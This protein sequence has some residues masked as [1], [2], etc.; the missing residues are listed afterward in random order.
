MNCNTTHYRANSS[1]VPGDPTPLTRGLPL[2][3]PRTSALR[4]RIIREKPFLKRLYEEWYAG[5]AEA[6]PPGHGAILELG[7]GAGFLAEHV[8]GL[9]TSEVFAV[10]GIKAILDGRRLPFSDGSLR[11]IV[12]TDVFHHLSEPGLFLNEAARAVRPGG[13]VVMIEPWVTSWS[14]FVYGRLHHEPFRPEAA[15]W[16]FPPAG[17]LSGANG[18]LPWIVFERDR[19]RF[20]REYP[21]W[22]IASIQLMMPVR[23]LLSGG[24]SLR[25]LTPGWTYDLW[26]RVESTME[27]WMHRLAMFAQIV[28]D[29]TPVPCA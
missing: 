21:S 22:A 19:T 18:A 11:A 26:R 7:S 3:D 4:G 2:D 29:R 28:L 13:R 6:I 23:Y 20:E 12:M 25:S 14:R 24:V 16:S 15:E 27:P 10:P 17:P 8:P 1:S 9:I 5:I